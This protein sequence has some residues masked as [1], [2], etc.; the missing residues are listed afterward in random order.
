MFVFLLK[1]TT[2]TEQAHSKCQKRK[3]GVRETDRKRE[4][5]NETTAAEAAQQNKRAKKA[6]KKTKARLN[7]RRVSVCVGERECAAHAK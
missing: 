1:F 7:T 5:A 6:N 2:G 4:S 3:K